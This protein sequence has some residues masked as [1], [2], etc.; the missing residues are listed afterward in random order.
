MLLIVATALAQDFSETDKELDTTEASESHLSGELGASLTTGNTDFWTVQSTLAG[1]HRF[2]SNKVGIVAG[3]LWGRA[4][5]DADEDGTLSALE[6]AAGRADNARKV[7]G[8]LRYDRYLGARKNSLY[9]LG[10]ALHDPFSGYDLRTHEQLGYSRLLL[11]SEATELVAELGI[12]YA[13]EDYV[14]GVEPNSANVIAGRAMLG[15]THALN[16]NLG[17]ANN[18][19]VYENLRDFEDARVLNTASLN[20]ALSDHL[21]LKVSHQ[22]TWDNVPVESFRKLDQTA[23]MTVVASVL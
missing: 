23:M 11:D 17:V 19:E 10:G 18:L 21:A 20:V 5:L 22:L 12:D 9:A 8:D 1:S 14:D 13:Q 2:E 3:T 6:I 15:F 7:Y 16:E 4:V